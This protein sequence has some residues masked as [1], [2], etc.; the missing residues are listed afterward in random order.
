M[1]TGTPTSARGD[2][3][4]SSRGSPTATSPSLGRLSLQGLPQIT[5]SEPTHTTTSSRDRSRNSQ[6]GSN[7]E[8]QTL[9]S[10]RDMM[11]GAQLAHYCAPKC[12]KIEDFLY[13]GSVQV[14]RNK[15]QLLSNGIYYII[16]T[17]RVVLDN[18]FE[19]DPQFHYLSWKLYDQG[20]LS[21][22]GI[23]YKSM[24]FIEN[25][26]EK[27][28]SVFI[29]CE[30]GVS[31]SSTLT[32]AY[33]MWKYNSRRDA[34]LRRVKE[35]RVCVSPNPGF[36]VQLKEWER[37]LHDEPVPRLFRM[38][39]VSQE[40]P[41]IIPKLCN[42]RTVDSRTAFVLAGDD[43]I[44]YVW[45]GADASNHLIEYATHHAERML[46]YHTPTYTDIKQ[47]DEGEEPE[48]F[49]ELLNRVEGFLRDY[50]EKYD[51]LAVLSNIA[52]ASSDSEDVEPSLDDV[53]TDEE[54]AQESYEATLYEVTQDGK[55]EPLES[56]DSEDLFPDGIYVLVPGADTP[57]A[58][59]LF[60]WVGSEVDMEEYD[61]VDE[62]ATHHAVK[63]K[64]QE[65]I[66]YEEVVGMIEEEEVDEFFDYFWDVE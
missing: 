23:F 7:D 64:E 52:V 65:G 48:V 39:P 26:R 2:S 63:F 12:S 58:G 17:A 9:L 30:K 1:L 53:Q 25:A 22:I 4:Y 6:K 24:D 55:Y 54:E 35:G 44:L 20:S 56:Y 34:S 27:G 50:T 14:A 46:R 45:T 31:R 61:S 51:D 62:L 38:A 3:P 10:A 21:L 59:T 11:N 33:H 47:V 15:E 8:R 37:M 19:N 18:Y 36:L 66:E 5:T 16:N 57:C 29:H 41:Q 28:Q 60:V 40:H 42:A 43:G 13:L 49:H 32:I